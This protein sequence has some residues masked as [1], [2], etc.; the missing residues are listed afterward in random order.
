MVNG[1]WYWE[2]QLKIWDE[3]NYEEGE[4]VIHCGV[5][6]ADSMTEAMKQIENYYGDDIIE[7]QMLKPIV[8]GM[9]FD[10]EEVTKEID[11]DFEINKKI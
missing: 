4:E 6:A 5:V 11:L 7:L 9:V 10:F 8:E 3:Y 2:Y 1:I